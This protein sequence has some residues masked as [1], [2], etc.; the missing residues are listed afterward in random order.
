VPGAPDPPNKVFL[1]SVAVGYAIHR[2]TRAT[3]T[4]ALPSG[5][6]GVAFTAASVT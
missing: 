3:S 6:I 2:H 1:V 5:D 4:T